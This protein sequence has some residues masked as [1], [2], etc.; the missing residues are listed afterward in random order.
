MLDIRFPLRA[1]GLGGLWVVFPLASAA[2]QQPPKPDTA[3]TLG[4]MTITA[5]P[6][7]EVRVQTMQRLTLP[8]VATITAAQAHQT[9]NLVDPEDAVKYLPSLFIRKRNY[10]DTQS[11][12]ATRVW[13]LSSSARSLVFADG[14]PLSA[15]IANNNNIGGPRWGL[16]STEE[17][18]RIDVMYGPF[19]AA[20]AGNSMGAV[21]E[22]TT[23][24]PDS[25][26]GSIEQTQA[27][28]RF[29][30]Y[31]TSRTFTTAQTNATL[32]SR[33]GRFS[34][35]ASGSYQDSHAQPLTYVTSGSFPNGTTGGYAEQNKLGAPAN[36]LG[37]TGLLHTGMTNIKVK[38]A[39]DLTPAVRAAYTFGVWNNDAKSSVDTY[40]DAS[41]Q[42][43]FGGQAGFATGF[44]D[45][46]QRH[47]AHSLS[48]RSDR[49][50]DWD[51]EAVG[52]LYRFDTDQQRFPTT[53][54]STDTSFGNTGRV[55]VLDGTGWSTI[56]LKG[57]WHR[58]GLL[59]THTLTFGVHEDDYSLRNPTYDTP[60]WRSETFANVFTE[61]DGKT[62][63]QAVWAQDAWMILPSLRF[64]FGGRYEWW[65]AYDGFNASG[66]TRVIQ[67]TV[68]SSRFSPKG[69]LAWDVDPEWRLTA[70]LGKAYRFA[71]AAELYQLVSTGA[72]FTSPDPDLRPDNDLSAE[73]RVART[74]SRGTAQL[75]LFQDD[76]HDAIIS[77]FLPLVPNSTTLYS[78]I[79]N[80]DHVRARGVEASISASDMLIRRLSVSASATYVDARTLALSGRASATAPAGSAIGKFL[81]NIPR[82]RAT[83][84]GTYQLVAPLSISLAGRY[85][86]KL[87]T[88]LD[89][90]DV[91]P[92]TYQGFGEWFV[93]D[94]RANYRVNA[95]WS[96]AV[97]VDNM[98]NRKYFLFHPFPQRTLVASVK[99]GL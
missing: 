54:S 46:A 88:T 11:T 9:V 36:V 70:S 38:L 52:A 90:A 21:M 17:I 50:G 40:L 41:G 86:G 97:G 72:T 27:M 80:V 96:A 59:A 66:N 7:H 48:L 23:R 2:T 94:A 69:I 73:L 4:P 53:A 87:Y 56:D 15:L 32:G 99:L 75:A 63:T 98:L 81:P 79:S 57:A 37:A 77:Q 45:L 44:Y 1:A 82:W 89:N 22:I 39:Y 95:R 43:T 24:Q 18:A 5:E 26:E 35:W 42:P 84:L 55:A 78:Y 92:N 64:T 65:R 91:N 20:Y 13:G 29:S 28:Q 67:P 6:V 60:D 14:V 33:L 25:L 12:I 10:G 30:L 16:V 71:T 76:V 51:F 31:G 8:A 68:R 62:R 49:K 83:F 93:M 19:S 34:F 3:V 58:G 85:S 74:F 47:F 61:G